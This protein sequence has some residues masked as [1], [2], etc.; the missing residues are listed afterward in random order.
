LGSR[1]TPTVASQILA[2]VGL[3]LSQDPKSEDFPSV[4]LS[5]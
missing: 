1:P 3:M 4:S 5:I 2:L